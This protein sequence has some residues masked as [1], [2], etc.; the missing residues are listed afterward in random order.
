MVN[1]SIKMELLSKFIKILLS[2]TNFVPPYPFTNIC[3][4]FHA[5]FQVSDRACNVIPMALVKYFHFH[6]TCSLPPRLFRRREGK[7][8]PP[9]TNLIL[10]NYKY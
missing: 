2:D 4:G 3:G 10:H 5:K 6:I 9:V 1:F 7:D 8:T